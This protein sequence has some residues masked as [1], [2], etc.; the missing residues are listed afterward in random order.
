MW[1]CVSKRIW[2]CMCEH[3]CGRSICCKMAAQRGRETDKDRARTGKR[4]EK[5]ERKSVCENI[6]DSFKTRSSA[7]ELSGRCV[8]NRAD[9]T[10]HTPAIIHSS[11]YQSCSWAE[12]IPLSPFLENGI[13]CVGS[14]LAISI[15]SCGK[16]G[17]K[18][19]AS[20]FHFHHGQSW[21]Q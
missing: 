8:S 10:W 7:A 14:M 12:S 11:L 15:F 18:A 19:A 4:D 21:N 16:R 20:G 17:D 3:S 9:E 5:E 13:D 2:Q 1:G 6:R